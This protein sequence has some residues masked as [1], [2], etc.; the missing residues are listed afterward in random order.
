MPKPPAA[1]GADLVGRMRAIVGKA[2]AENGGRAS[3]GESFSPGFE[4]PTA[5]G[6]DEP[7]YGG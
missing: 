1:F 3:S 2:G 7:E 6:G 5:S 4:Q